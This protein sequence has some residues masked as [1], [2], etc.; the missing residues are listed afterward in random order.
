MYNM[1]NIVNIWKCVNRWC[2]LN[3]LAVYF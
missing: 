2:I 1:L 3:F